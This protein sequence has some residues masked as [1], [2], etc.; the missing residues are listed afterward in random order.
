MERTSSESESGYYTE[1]PSWPGVQYSIYRYYRINHSGAYDIEIRKRRYGEQILRNIQIVTDHIGHNIRY[2]MIF[3]RYST[4]L[5]QIVLIDKNTIQHYINNYKY[6]MSYYYILLIIILYW[7]QSSF[8]NIFCLDAS[9]KSQFSPLMLGIRPRKS[10]ATTLDDGNGSKYP[11]N[12][13][14]A[15]HDK[16]IF[17]KISVIFNRTH[18]QY[19]AN[20]NIS[21][22][23]E[24]VPKKEYIYLFS[25]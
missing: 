16:M 17:T 2:F 23:D 4:I 25:Y 13:S 21:M 19:Y 11:A 5:E 18:H 6:S 8:W 20:I 9:Q 22:S 7:S 15:R 12:R 10:I 3:N 14:R 24:I 1:W